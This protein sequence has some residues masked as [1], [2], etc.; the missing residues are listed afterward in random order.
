M[1]PPRVQVLKDLARKEEVTV[2]SVLMSAIV[3]IPSCSVTVNP[4]L[5][6]KMDRP[7]RL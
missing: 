1:T 5:V 4:S 3:Q 2:N 6:V 7:P